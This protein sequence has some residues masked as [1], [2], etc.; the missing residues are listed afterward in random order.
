MGRR[1]LLILGMLL[2]A[3]STAPA[4]RGQGEGPKSSPTEPDRTLDAPTP[5]PA[6]LAPP[7][8]ETGS[9][10]DRVPSPKTVL[11]ESTK[12][13]T[14]KKS[15]SAQS[16]RSANGNERR[17][18]AAGPPVDENVLK[19]Q[20]TS[21]AAGQPAGAAD[22]PLSTAERLPVGK[23]QTVA[24]TVDVQAPASMNL[25]KDAT[26]KLI[27]RNTGTADAFNVRVDDELPESL[28]F[29]SSL[30]EMT[31]SG[32]GQH[33]SCVLS[34]LPGGSDRVITIKVTPIKTGPF[35]HAAT[36]RFET[37]YKSRTRVLE[38]KLKVDI[39]ANPTVGKV[40]KGQQVEFHISIQN[41]G[42]G[43]ARN[44]AIQ[45]KLSKGLKHESG[46]RGE[47]QMLY[48]LALP[49]LMPGATEKLDPLVADAIMGGEQSCTVTASS[50][51]V[52]SNKD[53]AESVKKIE[54][55]EPK[56]KITLDAPEQRYTDTVAD[57]KITLENPGTAPAR[58]VRIMATLPISGKL[59]KYSPEGRYDRATGK[60]S[61]TIDQIDPGAKAMTFPF[62]VRMGGIGSYDVIAD[63][64][65]E[66][67]LKA[68]ERKVTDVIG[69][70]DV[71]LVVSESKR[72]VDVGGST[73]FQIRL[74]NYGT[75]D[76]TH[77]QVTA[78]LSPNLKFKEA[79]TGA[80]SREVQVQHHEKD[81][82]VKFVEIDKLGP[83][84]ELMLGVLVTVDGPEPKLATC[85]VSVTHD[86]L[87]DGNKFEDMAGVKVTTQRRGAAT[88]AAGP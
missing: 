82:A 25:S 51:D 86:D 17:G 15:P 69:I 78:N 1:F 20:S 53:E 31:V 39:T 72:V 80:G 38:P 47:D 68:H 23:K 44:V 33:L 49:E 18:E 77:L 5:F 70:A 30:P 3:L 32:G 37:G 28:K 73:T 13:A 74:R 2:L 50:D 29:V 19:A 35:D 63:A 8:E 9:D 60:L 81:N 88:P 26:L 11:S 24:V 65:G 46:P 87:P 71:D 57:Y 59:A 16:D 21:Q 7:N 36:V 54:V 22:P 56:L 79:G 55:V 61:W 64:F 4:A 58:K 12:G 10:D 27:V 6:N 83:G 14:I 52:V 67:A 66:G 48:E 42:D 40:L 84:K 85:R 43:P 76:A 62:Q 45:A 34:T 75:K 41:T